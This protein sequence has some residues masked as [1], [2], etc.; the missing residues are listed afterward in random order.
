MAS[1]NHQGL[2]LR[3]N[4]LHGETDASDSGASAPVRTYSDVV[5]GGRGGASALVRVSGPLGMQA[6]ARRG[7]ASAPTHAAGASA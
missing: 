3:D 5:V 1:P 4:P 6:V 7:G 2:V